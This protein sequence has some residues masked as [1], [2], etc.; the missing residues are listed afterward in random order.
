[1]DLN[2]RHLIQ[3]ATAITVGAIAGRSYGQT[4]PLTFL[5]TADWGMSGSATQHE[6]G[7]TMG[8]FAA[9]LDS[10]FMVAVGDNFYGAGVQ[11]VTDPHWKN[12]FEDV[13]N[14][15]SLQKP[16]YAVMGNH[17]YGGVPQAQIDY[18][19]VSHRWTMPAR[20]FTKSVTTRDGA[21]VDMF[22]LDTTP[23]LSGYHTGEA[24]QPIKVNS[25]YEDRAIQLRWL[26]VALAA[27]KAPWKLAFGHHPVYSGGQHGDTREMVAEVRPLFEKYGVQMF[28]FGHDHD[29]QHI[30]RG[31]LTYIGTGAGAATREVKAVEGTRFCATTGGFT[32]Y[33]LTRDRLSIDFISHDGALL[34]TA[35]VPRVRA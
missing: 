34:H 23:L 20:Y 27:S 12:E 1:M 16:W 21:A 11:S 30:D 35:V 13:Y 32:A 5:A 29:L 10:Q 14:A 17:D 15:P 28:A 33:S 6:I 4:R 22:F 18:S 19:R 25:R 9:R 24:D 26:E 31:G 7:A 3:A 8:D 2:R